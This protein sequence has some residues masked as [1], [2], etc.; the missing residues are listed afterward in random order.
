MIASQY[1]IKHF[2][3]TKVYGQYIRDT[4]QGKPVKQAYELLNRPAIKQMLINHIAGSSFHTAFYNELNQLG[5]PQQCRNITV[6]N[7]S[8]NVGQGNAAGRY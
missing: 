7:G 8:W 3:D 2:Y 4:D 5:M 1:A 6:G